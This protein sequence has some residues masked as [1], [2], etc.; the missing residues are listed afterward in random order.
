MFLRDLREGLSVLAWG[1]C[2]KGHKLGVLKG[3]H[4]H[5]C[6]V[7]QALSPMWLSVGEVKVGRANLELASPLEAPEATQLSDASWTSMRNRVR[8]QEPKE[9]KVKPLEE[10]GG[11]LASYQ[12][13]QASGQ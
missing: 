2:D 11:F 6:T 9:T 7:T 1:F 10:K 5:R 8:F 4:I 13:C 12:N 3:T